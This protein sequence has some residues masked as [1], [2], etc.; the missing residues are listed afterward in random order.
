MASS[1]ARPA[2][3]SR[4][5]FTFGEVAGGEDGCGDSDG[6]LARGV[7]HGFASARK[8]S[9]AEEGDSITARQAEPRVRRVVPHSDGR[10]RG[11]LA[12]KACI[13]AS[14]VPFALVS[15]SPP[16]PRI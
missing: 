13:W 5:S 10:L 1:I 16:S 7:V 8:G 2:A 9:V 3:G 14:G 11:V 15:V 4:A 6:L 12:S